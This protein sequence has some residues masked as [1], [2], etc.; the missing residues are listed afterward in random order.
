MLAI[1]MPLSGVV[2]SIPNLTALTNNPTVENSVITTPE[3]VARK[4]KAEFID[5][6]FAKY[7]APLEGY[8]MK[9]VE[10]AEEHGLDYRLLP[11]IGMIESTGGIQKCHSVS[12]SVFGYGSCKMGFESIDKS[13]EIVAESLGG[14]NPKTSR[15]YEGKT[16]LQILRKYNSVIPTYPQKVERVMKKIHDDGEEII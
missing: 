16:T 4:E 2:S 14:D 6:Y 9:F 12:N 5:N 7:D 1:A 15:H 10:E 3:E 13:I 11:A 8:G